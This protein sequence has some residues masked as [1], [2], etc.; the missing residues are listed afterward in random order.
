MNTTATSD[1]LLMFTETTPQTTILDIPATN[2]FPTFPDFT[3]LIETPIATVT[4]NTDPIYDMALHT[5]VLNETKAN[6]ST[7]C[8]DLT[9]LTIFTC[10]LVVPVYNWNPIFE[11]KN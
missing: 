10:V 8:M 7:A 6:T 4:T 3:E 1:S 5:T 9:Q 2:T 11:A